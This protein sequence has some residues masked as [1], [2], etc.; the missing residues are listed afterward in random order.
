MVANFNDYSNT[1]ISDSVAARVEFI[2]PEKAKEYLLT[3]ENN[4]NINDKRVA[5]YANRMGRGE[6][7]LGQ[8][9]T[10]DEWG[11]LIDGQHRLKAIIRYGEP[12]E[13]SV[14]TGLPSESKAVFDIG[15]QRNARQIAKLMNIDKPQLGQRFAVINNAFFGSRFKAKNKTAEKNRNAL[16]ILSAVRGVHSPQTLVELEEKYSDGIDFAIRAPGT[17]EQLNVVGK[18]ALIQSVFFRAYYN[19]NHQR[20]REFIDVYYT[21]MCSSR[22]DYAA[23]SLRNYIASTKQ[24]TK[25]VSYGESGRVEIY[26][27]AEMAVVSF[28]QNKVVGQLRASEYEEFPLADFD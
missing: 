22:D 25:K 3:Q 19:E 13:F 1:T 26:K 17:K 6:W 11:C 23:L 15:Q 7:K 27:K 28:L 21:G 5:D 8:P 2:T 20:L 14:L 9:I 4:R 16:N 24:G 18:S 10:F 12:V